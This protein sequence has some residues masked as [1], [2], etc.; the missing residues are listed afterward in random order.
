MHACCRG[1]YMLPYGADRGVMRM[2]VWPVRMAARLS[3][4]PLALLVSAVPHRATLRPNI[5]LFFPDVRA[6]QPLP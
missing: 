5:F 6:R 2:L 3:L 4:L 1:H